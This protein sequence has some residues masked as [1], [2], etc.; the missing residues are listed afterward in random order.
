MTAPKVAKSKPLKIPPERESAIV[1]QILAVI[2]GPLY[3]GKVE[4]WRN[5]TGAGKIQCPA[6]SA[7][8]FMRF[9]ALGSADIFCVVGGRFL[10]LEVKAAKGKTSEA[11]EAWASKI[12]AVGGM[13]VVVRS[14]VEA[15]AAVDKILQG[16]E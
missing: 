3:R 16:G 10:G 11:Q 13:V 5:N 15:R 4:A 12:R 14:V 7:G 1:G 6:G 8:R 2:C 9:G